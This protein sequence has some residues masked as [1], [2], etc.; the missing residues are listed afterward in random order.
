VHVVGRAAKLHHAPAHHAGEDGAG[1]PPAEGLARRQ[2]HREPQLRLAHAQR[3]PR[4]CERGGGGHGAA[5]ARKAA[6]R[7][8][9]LDAQARCRRGCWAQKSCRIWRR[10]GAARAGERQEAELRPEDQ[11]HALPDCVGGAR[12]QATRSTPVLGRWPCVCVCMR[13]RAPCVDG[14]AVAARGRTRG[15]GPPE[16][17]PALRLA[18]LVSSG[19]GPPSRRRRRRRRRLGDDRTK[20]LPSPFSLCL[21]FFTSRWAGLVCV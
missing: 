4:L 14:L 1:A 19:V 6:A 7:S 9:R 3:R 2:R 20:V 21:L 11:A 16:A 13:R 15:G 8:V 18:P 10:R 5:A 17:R 12:T